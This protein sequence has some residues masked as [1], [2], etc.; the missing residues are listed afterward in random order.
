MSSDSQSDFP[1]C[2]HYACYV[3]IEHFLCPVT[4]NKKLFRQKESEGEREGEAGEDTSSQMTMFNKET[5]AVL[6]VSLIIY[7]TTT[8]LV[9]QIFKGEKLITYSP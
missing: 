3:N 9:E 1:L 5:Q 7:N 2:P 4:V 6:A 8:K